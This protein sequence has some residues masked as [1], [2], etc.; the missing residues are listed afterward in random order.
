MS[1][2]IFIFPLRFIEFNSVS[3]EK[4]LQMTEALQLGTLE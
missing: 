2:V 3:G 1:E 4:G